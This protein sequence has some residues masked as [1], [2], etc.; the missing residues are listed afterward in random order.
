MDLEPIMP[1]EMPVYDGARV[2]ERL[3]LDGYRQAMWRFEDAATL[4]DNQRACFALFEALNWAHALD[5]LIGEVFRP[6][7]KREG[8]GWRRWVASGEG[9][10]GAFRWV[11][12]RVHHQWAD[13]PVEH[14]GPKK[15]LPFDGGRLLWR[16]ADGLPTTDK[17]GRA[18]PVGRELY[19]QRFAGQPPAYALR[20]VER[21][22]AYVMDTWLDFPRPT[23]SPPIV[24]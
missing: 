8:E 5:D 16:P 4:E 12:N 11:R 15:I 7:G 18:E 19:E 24:T 3:L 6:E 2:K 23:P 1:R 10:L 22:F 21:V 20:E 14:P 9:V 13:A 17:G